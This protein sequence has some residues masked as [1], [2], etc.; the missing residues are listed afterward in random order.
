MLI[1][2]RPATPHH[3]DGT[4]STATP[5]GPSPLIPQD[6]I[7]PSAQPDDA[8]STV[9][10]QQKVD[11]DE[12]AAFEADIAAESVPY[13]DD[14]V[15]SAPAMTA[16]EHAAN[17][18]TE[19]EE[20]EKRRLAAEKDVADEKEEATRALETEFEEMEELEARVR[21]LKERREALRSHADVTDAEKVGPPAQKAAVTSPTGKGEGDDEGDDEEEEDDDDD[22]DDFMGF[23]FGG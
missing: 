9:T 6:P 21:K 22:E 19:E 11:E 18:R 10:A 20:R 8:V 13:A 4:S 2:S 7:A 1:P 17:A 23:R 12:W 14:A 5:L 15:I 16:E 3:R